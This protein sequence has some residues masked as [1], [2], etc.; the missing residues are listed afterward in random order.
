MRKTI[1]TYISLGLAFLTIVS[2][3]LSPIYKVDQKFI[4]D[5]F[6]TEVKKI[7]EEELDSFFEHEFSPSSLEGTVTD[8]K[9]DTYVTLSGF[10]F[11]ISYHNANHNH[12]K[13]VDGL[14]IENG[15]TF[16]QHDFPDFVNMAI[17]VK[18]ETSTLTVKVNNETIKTYNLTNEIKRYDFKVESTERATIDIIFS[19]TV[20]IDKVKINEVEPY[21]YE[22]AKKEFINRVLTYAGLIITSASILD[23]DEATF[24]SYFEEEVE[25]LK[26]GG[27]PFLSLFN[28]V[29]EDAVNNYSIF[30]SSAGQS[31]SDRINHYIENRHCSFFS[32]LTLIGSLSIMLGAISIAIIFIIG[33]INKK[34]YNLVIPSLVV[35][36]GFMI[37]LN[38]STFTGIN[39]FTFNGEHNFVTEYRLLFFE[40]AKLNYSFVLSLIFTIILGV[41]NVVN[42]VID[43]VKEKKN[44]TLMITTSSI[45]S[46]ELILIIVGLII[47]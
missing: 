24:T 41:M 1:I 44:K 43:Y 27:I 19:D 16:T 2:I 47:R 30:S 28:M 22:E 34:E 39:F 37:L 4:L 42:I 14:K 6:D 11:E 32:I 40:S 23:M 26:E 9:G 3:F 15:I 10:A 12:S 5:N 31:L 29:V 18:G 13:D 35:I 33:I 21:T 45:L 38:M 7:T 17:F 46:L 8:S 20:V 25:T 36:A